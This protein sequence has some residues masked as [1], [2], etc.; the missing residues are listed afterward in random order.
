MALVFG[1][2]QTATGGGATGSTCVANAI[3]TTTGNLLVVAVE[4]ASGT[5]STSVTDTASNIY[6]Q[7]GSNLANGAQTLQMYFAKNITGNAANV[8]SANYGS[9]PSTPFVYV[10]EV[11]GADTA[12]PLDTSSSGTTTNAN[13][14]VSS[15]TFSTAGANEIILV[16][17][18]GASVSLTFTPQANYVLDSSNITAGS[19]TGTG[20]AQ[21]Q[22]WGTT[23]S[24]IS[25]SMG[26]NST[27]GTLGIFAA[28][29]KASSSNFTPFVALQPAN[30]TVV[31]SKTATFLA[32]IPGIPAPTFQWFRN[33]VA[34][35]GATSTS[36]TTPVTAFSDSATQFFCVATNSQ[37][38]VQSNTAVLTVAARN[39]VCDGD[40][41]TFGF[42]LATP[43]TS[44]LSLGLAP[45]AVTNKGIVGQTLATMVTNAATNIDPLF[46]NDPAVT[47]VVVVWGG[48]ND[49]AGAASVATVEG[50]LQTYA[51]ARQAVG[52]KVVTVF[53]ISRTG[54]DSQKDQYNAF[55]QASFSNWANGLVTLN[56]NLT[57]DGAFSNSAFFQADAIHPNQT[58]ATTI[59]APAVSATLLAVAPPAS[60]LLSNPNSANGTGYPVG[61]AASGQALNIL[62]TRIGTFIAFNGHLAELWSDGAVWDIISSSYL[63]PGRDF[64]PAIIERLL[65]GL[66]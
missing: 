11:K 22:I 58:S 54:L 47:N 24:N 66:T 13:G 21:H 7:I 59:I 12:S 36:Y 3:A 46:V 19:G 8:V 20:G 56:S 35:P 29:F 40:S 25:V 2:V 42:N 28:A 31:K 5:A 14:V 65:L 33:G 39:V 23:Q 55:M 30:T 51:T 18:C 50:S 17:A 60:R 32:S 52:W 15:G 1:V 16:A 27:G 43:W 9:A 45:W 6:T 48:T 34:I 4:T 62:V 10:W 63:Y 64:N 61:S 53:M 49:F 41:I 26:S 37:G 57:A 44:S 38:I